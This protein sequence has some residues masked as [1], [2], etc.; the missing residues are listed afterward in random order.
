MGAA[1]GLA[2]VLGV[3]SRI[4]LEVFKQRIDMALRDMVLWGWVD[5]LA[6]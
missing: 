4:S 3:C 2:L 5:G 1:L 6:L